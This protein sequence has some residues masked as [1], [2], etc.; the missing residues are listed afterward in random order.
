MRVWQLKREGGLG[1]ALEGNR[2]DRVVGTGEALNL[3]PIVTVAGLAVAVGRFRA[4]QESRE[5]N[6]GS[7]SASN[8]HPDGRA[9]RCSGNGYGDVWG[10]R[11]GGA[12][13]KDEEPDPTE[14]KS[15]RNDLVQDQRIGSFHF[16]CAHVVGN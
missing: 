3:A 14:E 12:K 10:G 8:E 5:A 16:R 2:R 1:T 13:P 15:A 4:A 7:K 9:I 6:D 11:I